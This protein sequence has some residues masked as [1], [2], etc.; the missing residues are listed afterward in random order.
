MTMTNQAQ[1]QAQAPAPTPA[2]PQMS[3][4]QLA[5]FLKGQ[6]PQQL[7]MN[8]VQNS[9]YVD[10]SVMQLINFAQKGDMNSLM[11]LAT[12]IMQAQGLDLNTTLQSFMQLMG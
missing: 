4:Q 1:A 8:L 10:P 5:Q 9:G 11:N 3:M 12:S 2:Q 7:V 6:N